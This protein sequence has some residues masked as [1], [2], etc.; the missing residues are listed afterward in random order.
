MSTFSIIIPVYN[1]APYLRE[2]LDSVLKQTFTDWESICVDDGSTDG[3]GAI[4]DEYAAKDKR[5]KVIHKA[6][7]G[8]SSARNVGVSMAI[9]GYLWFVDGDDIVMPNA[10]NVLSFAIDALKKP[11]I[12]TLKWCKFE[13]PSDSVFSDGAKDNNILRGASVQVINDYV[14]T[15]EVFY[16]YV[17]SLICWNALYRKECVSKLKFRDYPN[18]EDVLWGVE[19]LLQAQS[20]GSISNVCYGYFQRDGSAVRQLNERHLVSSLSV[21]N[22]I[23]KCVRCSSWKNSLDDILFKKVWGVVNSVSIQIVPLL[24]Q[25]G[26]DVWIQHVKEIFLDSGLLYGFRKVIL[27][28]FFSFRV[29]FLIWLFYF[30]PMKLKGVLIKSSFICRLNQWKNMRR[31][32]KSKI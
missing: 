32:R 18:G 15:R 2:C 4:L 16:K 8:V 5:F 28:F 23:V 30:F 22:E 25:R 11:D 26:Y 20:V 12:I 3:S 24:G 21:A 1:V 13:H 29:P 31:I 9:G 27:K 17:G 6:N 10:L 7:G 19:A 14:S